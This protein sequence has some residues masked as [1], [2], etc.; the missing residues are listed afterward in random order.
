MSVQEIA[1]QSLEFTY[2]KGK[3]VLRRSKRQEYKD[4]PYR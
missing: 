1:G 3:Y 2:H 4:D